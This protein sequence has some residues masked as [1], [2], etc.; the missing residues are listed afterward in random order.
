MHN[1]K[2]RGQ[3]L[4]RLVFCLRQGLC[5]SMPSKPALLTYEPLRVLQS[6]SPMPLSEHRDYR[7]V[8]P[9]LLFTWC[10]GYLSSASTY[11]FNQVSSTAYSFSPH[12]LSPPLILSVSFSAP[13]RYK[14]AVSSLSLLCVSASHIRCG[15]LS[16]LME[17][18]RARVSQESQK[19]MGAEACPG[20]GA[21]RRQ[22]QVEYSIAG[23][24]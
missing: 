18:Y 23:A 12:A 13:S 15:P 1:V 8:S 19:H 10:P 22:R 7:N 24:L 11:P 20:R 4:P 14:K 9:R 2:V 5:C 21:E 6:L 3:T 16:S 17:A